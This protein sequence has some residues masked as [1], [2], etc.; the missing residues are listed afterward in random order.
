VFASLWVAGMVSSIG[1]AMQGV[2][3]TWMIV[4]SDPRPGT[5]A[6]L[7]AASSAPLFL[8]GLPAGVLADI[9]DRRKLL[10]AANLWMALAAGLLAVAAAM[11]IA[12]VTTLLAAT[13]AIG[14][15]AAAAAPA[16]QAIVPELA[17]GPLLGPAV[18]LNS[19]GMN[20][21]RTIGP[22][23]GG[24]AVAA[25]GGAVVFALNAVSTLC[26]V[27]AL[28]LWHR[29]AQ[30]RRL[31]P[32]H[33]L[34]ATRASLHYVAFAPDVRGV[35]VRAAAF[36]LFASAG[37][38]LLPVIASQRLHLD[39]TG[40][41]TLLG[42]LGIGAVLS[43]LAIGRLKA[44]L[45]TDRLI[46]LA[47]GLCASCTIA[48]GQVDRE[49]AALVILAG[50]GA[51]WIVVLTLLN[52]AVQASVAGWIRARMLAVYVVVYFGTFAAGSL[53][54]GLVANRAG[55]TTTL[56]IAGGLGV[57][58]MVVLLLQPRQSGVIPD[59]SP[60]TSHEPGLMHDQEGGDGA[61]LV[62]VD[63]HVAET[64]A[65]GFERALTALRASRRR[66]GALT[67]RHWRDPDDAQLH[68][69]AYLVESWI[70]YQ[71][72]Q[73]RRTRSDA[74]L[75]HVAA[76]LATSPPAVRLLRENSPLK[77]S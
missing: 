51:G 5:V 77:P 24:V 34:S 38:A 29:V 52:V 4:A 22:A 48:L 36:F 47:A 18:T 42:A 20:I 10:I 13:F 71:R 66:S 76:R 27:G 55:T 49:A 59:L 31:P 43:A 46:A 2:G 69:E 23:L 17:E 33:F 11:G 73:L 3:A 75:E 64:S 74:E 14:L 72:Q 35:L 54:W 37:W 45:G 30:P 28:F 8:V 53:A 41:G 40:Y 6:L 61:V 26:V 7:Q 65:E 39:A 9:V 67:W 62:S 19:V 44:L 12:G 60:A 57:V 16:F 56:V 63:Y 68:R 70:E 25:L 58:Y 50:F 1:T 15:G 21:A 32:E